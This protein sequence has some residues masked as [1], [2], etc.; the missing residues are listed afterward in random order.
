MIEELI[1]GK[2]ELHPKFSDAIIEMIISDRLPYY[3]YFNQ[4]V[5]FHSSK[6]VKTVANNVTAQGMNMYWNP[7]YMDTL[8]QKESNWILIYMTFKLML[9][10][11]MRLK[12]YDKYIS[13]V[14]SDMII[15]Q[16]I[17]DDIMKQSN[18]FVS[19][20]QGHKEF[21]EDEFG[22]PIIIGDNNGKPEYMQNPMYNKNLT[23]YIPK[24]YK[25]DELVEGLYDFLVNEREKWR[26]TNKDQVNNLQNMMHH[27]DRQNHQN[28]PENVDPNATPA[29]AAPI[30]NI[31]NPL[32]NSHKDWYGK[33]GKNDTEMIS[34]EKLFELMEL[35]EQI[36]LA[37][38][39]EDEVPQELRKNFIED[40]LQKLKA[41]GLQT[42]DVDMILNKLR[43]SKKDYLK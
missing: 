43:K 18:G 36:S 28:D 30:E 23:V 39:V 40:Y 42:N 17:H 38:D 3:G 4:F 7:D 37:E 41:R 5:N 11:N 31:E 21:F 26:R 8:L 27:I 14:A 34:L 24:I 29:P 13:A 6:K 12:G 33:Y 10:H 35:E 15:N 20:P 16:I 1:L 19:I 25:G 22:K 32:D 2:N 9:N